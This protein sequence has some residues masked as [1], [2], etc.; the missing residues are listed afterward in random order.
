MLTGDRQHPQRTV[1]GAAPHRDACRR[2]G[3][4]GSQAPV[5]SCVGR[6]PGTV[7]AGHEPAL[8]ASWP[9]ACMDQEDHVDRGYCPHDGS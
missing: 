5:R 3:M 6:A 2:D 8:A 7:A 1:W 9:V 4:A